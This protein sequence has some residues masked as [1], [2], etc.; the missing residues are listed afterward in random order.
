MDVDLRGYCTWRIGGT[1]SEVIFPRSPREF[2][3]TVGSLNDQGRAFHVL[4]RGSNVLFSKDGVAE[5]LIYTARIARCALLRELPGEKELFGST[6]PEEDK[7]RCVYV[8]AGAPISKLTSFT[9]ELGLSGVESLA[10]IPGSVG[11]AVAMNAQ[12]FME[13]LKND[14][15]LVEVSPNDGGIS[16]VPASKHTMGYRRCGLMGHYV[17]AVLLRLKP[18]S[19]D[20]TRARVRETIKRKQQMQ[21][22]ETPSAGCVFLNPA[23]EYAGAL[24]DRAGMKGKR[25]GGA[26]YSDKHANFILN[27]GGASSDD[28]LELMV[29]GKRSVEEAFGRCLVPEIKFIGKFL[30]ETLAFLHQSWEGDDG[31]Q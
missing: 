11:G 12:G 10:G 1:A 22:L 15:W 5:P 9:A 23:G 24:L 21:P 31:R 25:C 2:S 4:G 3:E 6:I 13:A 8:E 17:I 7:S 16:V 28:V 19:P 14:A 26:V 27:S 29:L 18:D 20:D 30:S